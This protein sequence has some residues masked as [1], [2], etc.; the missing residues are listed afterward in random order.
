MS[1]IANIDGIPLYTTIAEAEL[2]ASQYNLTGYHTHVINDQVGYMGGTDHATII[3]AMNAGA[4]N[5][6]TPQQVQN[7]QPNV[8]I[9]TSN[10]SSGSSGSGY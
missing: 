4:V 7:V 5:T 3:A 2:W 1:F 10:I 6:I 8:I 9:N